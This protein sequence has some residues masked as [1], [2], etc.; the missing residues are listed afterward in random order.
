MYNDKCII[1]RNNLDN[2][3][4]KVNLDYQKLNDLEI[5]HITKMKCGHYSLITDKTELKK[6]MFIENLSNN[7]LLSIEQGMYFKEI[8]IKYNYSLRQIASM[9]NKNKNY[10]ANRLVLTEFSGSCINYIINNRINNVTMLKKI[11]KFDKILHIKLLKELGDGQ[12]TK[13][14]MEELMNAHLK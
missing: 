6:L 4:C 8:Q 5:L 7:D 9:T 2:S 12:L 13:E 1:R 14:L 11:L 3:K 10:I